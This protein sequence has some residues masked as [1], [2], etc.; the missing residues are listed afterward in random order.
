MNGFPAYHIRDARNPDTKDAPDKFPR[1]P[2]AVVR[3]LLP[4]RAYKPNTQLSL[5]EMARRDAE[6]YS[7]RRA[8]CACLLNDWKEAGLERAISNALIGATGLQLSSDKSF[9]MPTRMPLQFDGAPV[10][11]HLKPRAAYAVGSGTTGGNL[12]ETALRADDFIEVLRNKSVIGQ[13]GARYLTG[14]TGN[15]NIP[16]QATQTSV[17]WVGESSAVSESE[18]TFDQVQ[19][20]PHTVGSFSKMSR[21]TLQQTTPAIE[22]LV[23]DDLLNVSTL[24]VDLAALSG[25]GSSSQPTGITNTSGIGTVVAGTNGNNAT[26]DMMIALYTAPAVANAP[27]EN[28]GFAINAKTRGYLATLKSSAGQYLWVPGTSIAGALPSDLV[29]QRY[30]VSNQLPSNLTKGTSGAVCSMA[31]YGNWQELFVGEWGVTEIMVNPYDSTGF[32][33]GDVLVRAFTTVDIGLRHPASFAVISDL[34]TPG[35]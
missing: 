26:F 7:I 10:S 16:R 9:F 18:A 8:I 15:V 6:Q 11:T 35:F 20:R 17:G 27:Q 13:L 30:A 32:T 12:V 22:Q 33:T 29:G 34:L 1:E 28:L 21:L 23:R 24:A 25:T 2:E 3:A 31:I 5:T 4:A 19:L 14:L